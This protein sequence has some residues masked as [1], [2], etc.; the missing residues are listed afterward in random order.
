MEE[1][2]Y[3]LKGYFTSFISDCILIPLLLRRCDSIILCQYF[4]DPVIWVGQ[5][6]SAMSD[7]VN[8][9]GLQVPT[10]S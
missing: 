7:E 3:I 10:F 6:L 8:A 9:L 4:P 5:L 1:V 2:I